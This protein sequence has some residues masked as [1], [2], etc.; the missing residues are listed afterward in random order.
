[1]KSI[2]VANLPENRIRALSC[3]A[4]LCSFSFAMSA[5]LLIRAFIALMSFAVKMAIPK[6]TFIL[7]SR[8]FK[9]LFGSVRFCLA[10]IK[11]SAGIG[12][13]LYF[14]FYLVGNVLIFHVFNGAALFIS[15]AEVAT[16]YI[17]VKGFF[18]ASFG[19]TPDLVGAAVIVLL[20]GCHYSEAVFF[21]VVRVADFAR[22]LRK[23]GGLA[24]V[25]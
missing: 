7:E 16:G 8:C 1:M 9:W 18:G 17:L 6:I 14:G 4:T 10:E 13:I 11:C 19:F 15:V 20:H 2:A 25:K 5:A 24:F 12:V 3:W 21:S 23:S 22:H